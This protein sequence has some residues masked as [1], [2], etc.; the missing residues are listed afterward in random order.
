MTRIMGIV[1]L[2]RDSFS[3]GDRFLD[4]G[5]ALAH[6]R[7]LLEEGADLVDLGAESTHP[8]SEDVSTGEELRRL[9]PVLEPLVAEGAVVSVDTR[10]PEVMD[11]VCRRGAA[12]VNDVTA[13]GLPGAVE[14]V[15]GTRARVILMHA[16]SEEGR[17]RREEGME[18]AGVV[19]RIKAWFETRLADLEGA[20]LPRERLVL[21]PG[22]GFFLS[23]DPGPSLAVL[24]GLPRLRALGLPL[25]VSTSRKSFI[26]SLLDRPV[27]GRG[28]GTLATEIHAWRAGVE[29]IR[30]HDV[31]SLADAIRV[32]QAVDNAAT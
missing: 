10:K 4:P 31:R 1:N 18:A 8:D 5:A 23:P 9:L 12:Y 26:G 7:R 19:A 24:K 13:L 32:L 27:G 6:A 15:R 16:S 28:A 20:G 29:I 14:A 11:E 22:M 21:D 2:T 17:A 30:T 3:D 25:C